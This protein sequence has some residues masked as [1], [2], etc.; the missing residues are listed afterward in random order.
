VSLPF[1]PAQFFEVMERYNETVFPL[2]IALVL[3]G[4][5]AYGAMVVRRPDSDRVIGAILAALWLWGGI[6]YHYMSFREINNAA[7]V[8]AVVFVM[9]ALLFLWAGLRGRA[10]FDNENAAKRITGHALIAYA[11]VVYPVM[12]V[13]VGRE[14]PGLPTFGLP[15]PTTIFTIGMLC[16]LSAPVPRYVLAIP[17]A[18]AFVGAQAAFLLGV[19]ED[20]GLLVAGIVGL[21]LAFDAS[22]KTRA[23]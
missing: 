9:G 5:T 19:Y 12:S 18:W 16:F 14:F 6:V 8:F 13:S 1:T 20:L 17:I 23:A 2:Q 22:A 10:V 3:L 15:C 21:W 11:L 4:L 7:S